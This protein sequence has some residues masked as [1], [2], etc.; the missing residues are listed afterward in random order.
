[1]PVWLQKLTR[2][3]ADFKPAVEAWL[4]GSVQAEATY[5]HIS[6]WLVSGV[7]DMCR[8]FCY[9]T[10]FNEDLSRWDVS[11]VTNMNSMFS[12]AWS[13][14]QD[15]SRWDVSLVTD[16]RSIFFNA[17]SLESIPAW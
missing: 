14:N 10:G 1:M 6:N 17:R 15:L 2:S 12:Q 7:T 9:D 5:G 4:A 8:T 11:S 13:F 16:M 3:D